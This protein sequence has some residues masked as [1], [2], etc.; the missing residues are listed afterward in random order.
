MG[1]AAS[2]SP[3]NVKTSARSTSGVQLREN[4]NLGVASMWAVDGDRLK[5]V[6][7]TAARL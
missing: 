4:V 6:S 1:T 5:L 2:R 7:I 3:E